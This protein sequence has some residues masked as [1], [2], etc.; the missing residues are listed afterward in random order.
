MSYNSENY[1]CSKK[2]SFLKP[3][4]SGSNIR[5]IELNTI[6]DVTCYLQSCSSTF[7]HKSMPILGGRLKTFKKQ[8]IN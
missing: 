8:K 5:K 1:L 4:F 3:F 2:S 6:F 7:L